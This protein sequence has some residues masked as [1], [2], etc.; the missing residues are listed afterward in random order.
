M[1]L[2]A[3]Q[4]D[5]G[6]LVICRSFFFYFIGNRKLDVEKVMYLQLILYVKYTKNKKPRR[7][8]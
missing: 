6:G 4:Y 1:L 3:K 7:K 2:T 5:Q 8:S